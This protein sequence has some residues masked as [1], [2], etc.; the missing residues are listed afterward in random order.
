MVKRIAVDLAPRAITV[1]NIQPGPTLTD[2]TEAT[3]IA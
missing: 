1:N 2:M 3:S